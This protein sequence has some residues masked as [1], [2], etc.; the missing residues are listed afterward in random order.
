MS[1][2]TIAIIGFNLFII[3]MLALDLGVFHRKTHTVK[4]REALVWAAVWVSLAMTFNVLIYFWKGKEAALEF[5]AGYLIEKSLS[6]DN[7]F[8]FLLVF[9]YF[10]VPSKRQHKI[11]YWGIIGAAFMRA[12]LILLGTTLITRFHWIIYIF[13]AFLV[14]TGIKMGVSDDES[15]DPK[16]NPVVK[17]FRR[18]FPVAINYSGDKFFTRVDGKLLATPV[19]IVLIVIETTDLVFAVDSIPAIFAVTTDPF[20]VY[21]SNIFAIL[22]LR[23]LY[24]ALA[25]IMELF[26]HLKLGLSIVLTFVGAKMLLTDLYH[27]PIGWALAIIAL[28]LTLSVLASVLLPHSET[29]APEGL[30]PLEDE[31]ED[32]EEDEV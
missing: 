22:G 12:T 24:F 9:S 13:G 17:L 15:I 28:V 27:I 16:D 3:A 29:D 30:P 25:G 23:S 8:V 26:H 4:V 32:E 21:T 10:A 20:I 19:F 11:L 1:T 5:L 18:F 14:F 31:D 7:L 2:N 6:V